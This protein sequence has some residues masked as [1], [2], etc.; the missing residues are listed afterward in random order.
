MSYSEQDGKVVLTLSREDYD[1][2]LLA[3][4]CAIGIEAVDRQA[5]KRWFALLNRIN[6]GNPSYTPY[7]IG[8]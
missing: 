6:Q 4:G 8:K 1:L 7:E 3:L 5:V 2:L